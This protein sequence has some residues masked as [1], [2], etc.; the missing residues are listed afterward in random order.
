[1]AASAIDEA[2]RNAVAVG[3]DIEK[4]AVLDNFCWG[5]PNRPEIL[6]SLVRAAEACYDMA[7]AYQVPFISGKDSLHNEYSIGKKAYSIPAA[8]LISAVGVIN[9]VR[10]TITMDLKEEGNLIYILGLTKNEMAG[11]QYFKFNKLKGG[12]VPA[13]DALRSRNQMISLGAAINQGLVRSCHDCSEGGL[14]VAL[15][16]MAFA[17]NTGVV[18][19]LS[20]VPVSEEMGNTET[21]FSESNSRFIVEVRPADRKAFETTMNGFHC[22]CAGAVSGGK[23]MRVTGKD[24]KDIVKE[25]IEGLRNAWKKTL[26]W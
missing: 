20:K 13:V 15:A 21:A 11:S 8:L 12:Q 2:L 7:K 25:R 26:S 19:D 1:M 18:F 17:G 23:Y 6:G 16:E 24:G 4:I 3:G 10:K 14:L 22:V 9:D 5:N